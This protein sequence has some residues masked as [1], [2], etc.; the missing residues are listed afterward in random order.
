MQ[1]IAVVSGIMIQVGKWFVSILPA[2]LN[3]GCQTN[4]KYQDLT[5]IPL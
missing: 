2:E 3:K 1:Q 4:T 5:L